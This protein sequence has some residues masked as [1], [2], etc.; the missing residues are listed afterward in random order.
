VL[1]TALA[2][3]SPPAL[4]FLPLSAPPNP[5]PHEAG[6]LCT[7][8]SWKDGSSLSVLFFSCLFFSSF[9]AKNWRCR[10]F[11]WRRCLLDDMRVR[12]SAKFSNSLTC[13]Y[14]TPG[15]TKPYSMGE[16]SL[17]N[18]AITCCMKCTCKKR[19]VVAAA[20]ISRGTVQIAFHRH[21]MLSTRR[22]M[23]NQPEPSGCQCLFS[24]PP[25]FSARITTL[26]SPSSPPQ[27]DNPD[28]H[29]HHG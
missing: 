26:S 17:S 8:D 1:F 19:E 2:T 15:T 25:H 18:K 29:H 5:A 13:R 23:S 20:I 6:S 21:L 10:M 4:S 12:L 27:P 16:S 24:G 9:L 28:H 11:C 22:I 14:S 3:L 7:L